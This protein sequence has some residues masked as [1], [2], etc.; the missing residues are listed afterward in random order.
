MFVFVTRQLGREEQWP[1]VILL[2]VIEV[3]TM[4]VEKRLADFT[5]RLFICSRKEL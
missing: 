5:T 1:T 3:V 2:L 4:F